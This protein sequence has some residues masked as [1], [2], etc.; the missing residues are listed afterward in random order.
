[1]FLFFILGEVIPA[2][3][4]GLFQALKNHVWQC[5]GTI[6]HAADWTPVICMQ[7]CTFFLDPIAIHVLI[8][9][10]TNASLCTYWSQAWAKD[11]NGSPHS[12]GVTHIAKIIIK[13]SFYLNNKQPT[14]GAGTD[15]VYKPGE[16]TSLWISAKCYWAEILNHRT[17][18][19]IG[20]DPLL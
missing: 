5:L 1:M 18:S 10:T 19:A 16:V 15:Q 9:K 20:V 7:G 13:N 3:A 8:P 4:Q 11:I 12:A 6:W 14:G 2:D 17:H